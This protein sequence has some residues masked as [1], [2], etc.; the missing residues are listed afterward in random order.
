MTSMSNGSKPRRH[1]D[2]PDFLSVRSRLTRWILLF[3]CTPVLLVSDPRLQAA[4]LEAASDYEFLIREWDLPEGLADAVTAIQKS[5]DGF[6]WV[7]SRKGL[8]RFDGQ[9]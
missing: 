9:N 7:A 2:K 4:D 6:L 3:L 5:A 1:R 8:G